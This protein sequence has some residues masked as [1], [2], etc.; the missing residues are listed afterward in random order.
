ML[1][2][3]QPEHRLPSAGV[4]VR[5]AV[6]CVLCAGILAVPGPAPAAAPVRGQTLL[7]GVVYSRQVE[8]TAHGPVV[9]HVISA[10]K[11][12][13]LYALKP[14]LSNDSIIGRE[15]VTSME[16]RVSAQ[17]TVAAVNGDLRSE[18]RRVGKECRSRWSPY[19]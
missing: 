2:T 7:P 4:V 5:R 14:V 9:I 19:H 10:P 11:P 15:R 17:A 16:K 6:I 13:G 12:T 3:T 8:F 1:C 18:E